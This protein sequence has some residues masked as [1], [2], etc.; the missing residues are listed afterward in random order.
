MHRQR[1]WDIIEGSVKGKACDGRK[2]LHSDLTS[3]AKYSEV[4]EQQKIERDGR[5][6][7]EGQYRPKAL[8]IKHRRR[9]TLY[10]RLD[11]ERGA[12]LPLATRPTQ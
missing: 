1:V 6:Q 3:T 7:I 10:T 5:L 8:C 2:R 9:T 4:K 12:Y 11:G